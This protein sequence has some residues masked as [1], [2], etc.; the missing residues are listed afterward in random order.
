MFLLHP[1]MFALQHIGMKCRVA[2]CSLVYRKSLELSKAAQGKT[3]VG[4]IINIMGNDVIR[5]DTNLLFLSYLFI[6]PIQLAIFAYFLYDEVGPSGM[7]GVGFVVFLIPI[8]YWI[9]KQFTKNRFNIAQRTDER[10]RVMNEIII[11][12]RVIK[13]YAWEKPF[14]TMVDKIRKFEVKSLKK[15]AFL[16]AMYLSLYISSSRLVTYCVFIAYILTNH[17]LTA[18]KVF[19][20]LTIFSTVRQVMIS[21]FPTA[22]AA[23]GELFVSMNRIETF[24][25]LEDQDQSANTHF[26]IG[27]AVQTEKETVASILMNDAEAKWNKD[28]IALQNF[29]LDLRGDQLV[30]VVGSVGSGKTSLLHALLG[31]LPVTGGTCTVNGRTAYASQEAWIFGGNVRQNILFGNEFEESRY[32]E[33]VKVCALEDDF[34]QLPHGDS[35][36]VGERGVAL[37]GGQKARVNLARGLYQK[38]DI[39]LMDDPLS[40]VDSRVSRHIFEQCMKAHLTGYLRILCTHQL[41]YLPQADHILVLDEGKIKCQGTYQHLVDEGIDFISLM[42]TD[43][44]DGLERK[45][46]VVKPEEVPKEKKQDEK[47][48]EAQAEKMAGGSVTWGTYWEYL[49]GSESYFGIFMLFIAF[50]SSQLAFVLADLWLSRWTS[51]EERRMNKNVTSSGTTTT[52]TENSFRFFGNE[53][54]Y[55]DGNDNHFDSDSMSRHTWIPKDD[56]VDYMG[57]DIY[58]YVYTG[59]VVAIFVLTK[60]RAIYFFMF[61]IKI[62]INVHNKMFVSLVR[63]PMK[64]FD[65]NPSGRVMNRFTKDIGAMDELLPYA[66]FDAITIFLLMISMVILII[67]SNYYMSIPTGILIIGLFAMRQYFIKTAR[68][69]K[70]I[71]A[72]SRSPIF[73][74]VAASSQGLVTIRSAKRQSILSE[75]FDGHQ[76]LHSST[77]Y[78]FI[79]ANRWFGIW[80]EV[81]SVVYL[82]VVTLSFLILST[83]TS[84]KSSDVG[85]AISSALSLTGIFQWGMRQ[86][87]ETENLMTSVER[88]M[89]YAKLEPEAALESK[90]DKKPPKG[91]PSTGEIQFKDYYLAYEEKDVVKGLNFTIR[92]KEKI[93]IVGRTG[94]GKSSIIAG[95]F[96]M[97]EPRGD[98]FIDGVRVNDIG[99]HDLRSN[100]SIIPQDPVL[101]SGTMRY[102]LDPFDQF[103]DDELWG[104]IN[105]VKLKEA[106]PA[107]DVK[108]SDGGNNF[109]VGERQLVCLAR[110]ILRKNRIIVMDEATAN[111]DPTTDNFIQNTIRTKFSDCTIITIAHRL[112][113]IID[114]DK[115]LVLDNGFLKEYDHPH[116]LLQYPDGHLSSMVKHTGKSSEAALRKIAA[117]TY[118]GRRAS[119]AQ[120]DDELL[121]LDKLI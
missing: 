103:K 95:L 3:T 88:A 76:D 49:K 20:I 32:N 84:Y 57:E 15:L 24:L 86:S 101:F 18:D 52:T 74:H 63:A 27:P 8:E 36:I 34:K 96:R 25:L 106:V 112:N 58:L 61:C 7:A 67:V 113:S 97:T 31:E 82:C 14:S 26:K 42:S 111:V 53:N 21:Y 62:S 85:L 55:Y 70:R 12:M 69:V 100:I 105:E 71:E 98:L 116:R 17:P 104:V 60:F 41:Q 23:I 119:F 77:W 50:L 30:M 35:T 37:S 13:M 80:L 56:D 120:K 102:N 54:E 10:G 51:A 89:E 40:A 2:C 66:F 115:V 39:Y 11:A 109:S 93:G 83:V 29:S 110:A 45:S 121:Q 91:W 87:A 75:Q 72:I 107:L 118:S 78:T 16:R 38:A 47:K 108:V 33:V 5:F 28:K 117:D 90:P 59:I 43:S 92:G 65:D 4:Q 94:A 114:C 99:L 1:T 22:A 44:V 73:T 9:G 68:D 64:F 6:G 79:S 19:F 81:M 48:P 46:S